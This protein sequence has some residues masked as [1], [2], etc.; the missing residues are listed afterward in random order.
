MKDISFII[1]LAIYTILFAADLISTLM[2]GEL[3]QYLEANPLF[4]FGGLPLIILLNFVFIGVFYYLYKRG[5]VSARFIIIFGMVAVIITRV[6]VI[7]QNMS[8]V[9]D[10]PTIQQAMAVTQEMK[11]AEV[12]KIFS[13]NFLPFFNGIIAW[14]FFKYDHIIGRKDEIK[15]IKNKKENRKC[16]EESD[17]E[18][19]A[20]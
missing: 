14:F 16:I 3:V 20:I 11:T 5:D 10:P 17:A 12:V 13:L 2:I 15:T 18:K 8:I 4:K 7:Q 6:I 1:L 9:N 19:R